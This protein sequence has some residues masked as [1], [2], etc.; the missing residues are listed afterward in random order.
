M[1]IKSGSRSFG[2]RVELVGGRW[3][4]RASR[5]SHPAL[6]LLLAALI[7]TSFSSAADDQGSDAIT[8][9]ASNLFSTANGTFHKWEVSE[10]QIL[11]DDPAASFVVVT[12]DLASIDTGIE[13]R[14]DHLRD[15]DFFDVEKFPTA[16]VR[17]DSIRSSG[18]DAEGRDRFEA[19]FHLDLHG[20]QNSLPGE[21]VL[22]SRSPLTVA[23]SL[24]VDRLD[25]GIGGPQTFWNPASVSE[26]IP[27]QFSATLGTEPDPTNE[28]KPVAP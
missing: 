12:V 27:I 4:S 28:P 11:V 20:V 24:L 13:D 3:P 15:P 17:V 22:V 25:F 9:V 19:T 18:V 16:T 23:G 1:R 14:D 10:S 6:A 8:F 26:E 5:V 2:A 21:F 7:F